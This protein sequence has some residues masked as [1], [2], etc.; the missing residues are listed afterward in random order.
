[1]MKFE[2]NIKLRLYNIRRLVNT[3][4]TFYQM[5]RLKPIHKSLQVTA[6]TRSKNSHTNHTIHKYH[7]E[8]IGLHTEDY[9]AIQDII[10]NTYHIY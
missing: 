1:M 5:Q 2:D 9:T 4:L 8:P 6:Q 7:K 3:Q 10:S